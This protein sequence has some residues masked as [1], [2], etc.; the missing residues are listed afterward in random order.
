MEIHGHIRMLGTILALQQLQ[1]TAQYG[2]R[3][4]KPREI[5]KGSAHQQRRVSPLYGLRNRL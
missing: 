3:L 1:C 4:G 5:G 2:F